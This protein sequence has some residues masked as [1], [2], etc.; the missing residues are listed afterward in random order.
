MGKVASNESEKKEE[1]SVSAL[2]KHPR[3]LFG[4]FS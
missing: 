2:I 1:V 3:F 4:L